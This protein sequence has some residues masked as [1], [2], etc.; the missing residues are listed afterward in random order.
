MPRR[1]GVACAGAP[2]PISQARVYHIMTSFGE[3]RYIRDERSNSHTVRPEP[4][5]GDQLWYSEHVCLSAMGK[6][7]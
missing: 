1:S 5:E 7:G 6:S 2:A 4:S 3:M